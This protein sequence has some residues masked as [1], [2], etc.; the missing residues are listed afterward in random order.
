M[1]T[2]KKYTFKRLEKFLNKWENRNKCLLVELQNQRA[3]MH[4]FGGNFCGDWKSGDGI[5]FYDDNEQHSAEP[6]EGFILVKIL[7]LNAI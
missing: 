1:E 4:V 2:G 5:L 6:E 7:D 3:I